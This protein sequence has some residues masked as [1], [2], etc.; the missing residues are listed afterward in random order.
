MKKIV[1]ALGLMSILYVCSAR[2][3]EL[4]AQ[5][6]KVAKAISKGFAN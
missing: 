4:T 3:V 1:L 2:S 6:L 5:Q